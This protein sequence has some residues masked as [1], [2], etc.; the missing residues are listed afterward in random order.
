MITYPIGVSRTPFT[1]AVPVMWH[2]ST[3]L[4]PVAMDNEPVANNIEEIARADTIR[5]TT[6]FRLHPPHLTASNRGWAEG[7]I[8]VS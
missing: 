4:F 7:A 8:T 5:R 6:R 3:L 2:T 1:V